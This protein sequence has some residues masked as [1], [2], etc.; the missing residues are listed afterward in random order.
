MGLRA[1]NPAWVDATSPTYLHDSAAWTHMDKATVDGL[2][3]RAL[4]RDAAEVTALLIDARDNES[5]L[6]EYFDNVLTPFLHEV[7]ER[8][9]AVE[10]TAADEHRVTNLVNDVLL[11]VKAGAVHTAHLATRHAVVA[12]PEGELHD[13]GARM[14][15]IILEGRGWAVDHLGANVPADDLDSYV[16]RRHPDAVFLSI[17]TAN[18]MRALQEAVSTIR[19]TRGDAAFPVIV[20]G[21]RPFVGHEHLISHIDADLV[22]IDGPHAVEAVETMVQEAIEARGEQATRRHA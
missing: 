7:G 5:S 10:I 17:A 18:R 6:S 21:G 1:V 13:V 8:W 16:V 20:V 12:C 19:R 9:A 11:H 4:D 2:V 22:Q 14:L 15:T 3:D